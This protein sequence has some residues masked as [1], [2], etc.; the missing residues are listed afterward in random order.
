MYGEVIRGKF[1]KAIFNC[2]DYYSDGRFF[3]L[4]ASDTTPGFFAK[5][6][7]RYFYLIRKK[8]M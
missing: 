6:H 8:I 3:H 7:G 4:V 1:T 2:Y 5:W